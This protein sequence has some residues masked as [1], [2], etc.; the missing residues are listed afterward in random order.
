VLK[1]GRLAGLWR[2]KATGRRVELTV[3]PIGRLLKRDLEVEAARVAALRGAEPVLRL[4]T[5][6]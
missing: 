2:V 3:E 1:D 5:P 6:P 4:S